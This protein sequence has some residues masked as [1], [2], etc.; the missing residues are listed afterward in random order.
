[1]SPLASPASALTRAQATAGA[2]LDG[3]RAE[4]NR[5]PL[6]VAL[7]V[8]LLGVNLTGVAFCVLVAWRRELRALIG[9]YRGLGEET[10]ELRGE[11]AAR[12]P[13]QASGEGREGTSK[14]AAEA[15]AE[16]VIL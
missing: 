10:V 14:P 3:A 13:P 16:A 9:R 12:A 4:R 15:E 1:V 11:A 5:A 7:L 2:L 8:T 6:L